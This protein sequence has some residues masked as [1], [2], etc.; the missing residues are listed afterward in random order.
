MAGRTTFSFIDHSGEGASFAVYNPTLNAGNVDGY[1]STTVGQPLGNFKAAVDALT[2]LNE[3]NIS[4]GAARILSPGTLPTNEDAQREQKLLVKYID[5]TTNKKYSFSIPGINRPLVAQ[6]GTDVVD[7]QNN[8]FMIA[9]I[10]AFEANYVSELGNAVQ[11]Y[12]ASMV[13]RNN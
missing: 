5:V 10:A 13:G 4:V 9:L 3:V 6:Q 1:V 8:A 12:G 2:L 11:V 7:I